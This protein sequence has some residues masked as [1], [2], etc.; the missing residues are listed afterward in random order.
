MANESAAPR[1]PLK[2]WLIAALV[3]V[4]AALA[5]YV[6][7]HMSPIWALISAAANFYVVL[8][9]LNRQ[10]RGAYF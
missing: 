8:L 3:A 7:F 9:I 2:E 1:R 10:R 5:E 6:T 4:L